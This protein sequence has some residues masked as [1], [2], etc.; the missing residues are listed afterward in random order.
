MNRNGESLQQQ[1]KF[2]SGV[3]TSECPTKSTLGQ[4]DL[5]ACTGNAIGS[6][7][8]G[9]KKIT[10]AI[11]NANHRWFREIAKCLNSENITIP[12]MLESFD[13][14]QWSE[15][16]VKYLM[17]VGALLAATGK[18]SSESA[19][20]EDNAVI[21]EAMN[22]ALAGYGIHVPFPSRENM[23]DEQLAQEQRR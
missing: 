2:V 4:S 8:Q 13:E 21:I 16:S 17:Y 3:Q 14:M 11:R 23:R 9:S 19:T 18:K 12:M 10:P 20:T 15:G 22:L 1:D 7:R 5:Q 6:T